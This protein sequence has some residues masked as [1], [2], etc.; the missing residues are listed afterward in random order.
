M[1]SFA[2]NAQKSFHI[3]SNSLPS[4]PHPVVDEVDEHLCR[5]KACEATSSSSSLCQKLDGLQ[6]L[7]DCIEKLLVLP[8]T[9]QAIVDN[10]SVDELLEGSLKL[11]DLCT[12]AKDMISQMKEC[13]HELESSLRRRRG[14]DIVVDV[15]K[16][17]NSRKMM[18]KAI[19]KALKG[20]ERTSSQ[21][22]NENSEIVS[23]LKETEA[24][25]YS[26]IESLLSFLAGPKLASKMNR[27]SLV[28]KLMQSKRV[29]CK[30]GNEV[31]MVDA[32]LY[33]II[34]HKFDILV[35]GEDVQNSLKKLE[36]CIRDIEEDLESLYRRLIKNRV[37]FL[38]I[39]NY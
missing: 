20:M 14:D 4:K 10:K 8:L 36:L 31:E 6:D 13:A 25:T 34:N 39:L 22:S 9:H 28:S 11:L 12:M 26:T 38:N 7:H 15:Q 21:K 16:Y 37:A 5:L 35:Q 19:H 27:W 24:V 30:D 29:A 23:L 3:R 1:D 33:S 17:M 2:T 32:A 18:K